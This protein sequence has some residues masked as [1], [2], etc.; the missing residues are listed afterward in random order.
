MCPVCSRQT[1]G[2]LCAG[3]SDLRAGVDASYPPSVS[4]AP[5]G[6][7]PTSF[8][9]AECADLSPCMQGLPAC[10]L[11]AFRLLDIPR[12]DQNHSPLRHSLSPARA[13]SESGSPTGRWAAFKIP[14]LDAAEGVERQVDSSC[15]GSRAWQRSHRISHVDAE[16]GWSPVP[17]DPGNC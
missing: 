10:P 12:P 6:D 7:I 14:G 5:D 4:R 3:A 1:T 15:L 2:G 13:W 17:G 11:L 16:Q 9:P 8:L